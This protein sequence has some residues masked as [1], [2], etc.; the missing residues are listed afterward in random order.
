MRC[1]DGLG[2]ASNNSMCSSSEWKCISLHSLAY[3][4]QVQYARTH[5]RV[6]YA[7]VVNVYNSEFV[8]YSMQEQCNT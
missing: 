1:M 5:E 7:T 3:A 8:L 2:D 6:S 4:Q